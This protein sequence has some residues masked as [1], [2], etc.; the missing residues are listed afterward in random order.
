MI[1]KVIVMME[2]TANM[3]Q[4]LEQLFFPAQRVDYI[5]GSDVLPP[6]LP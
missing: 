5:G 6:P 4:L 2:R 1:R 3:L